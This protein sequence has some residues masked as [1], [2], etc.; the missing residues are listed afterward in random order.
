MRSIECAGIIS[1]QGELQIDELLPLNQPS[2][3]QIIALFPEFLE[4]ND[5][6]PDQWSNAWEGGRTFE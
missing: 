1:A 2:Q 3:V 4:S 6:T 5:L